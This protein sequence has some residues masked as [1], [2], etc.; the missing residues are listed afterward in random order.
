MNTSKSSLENI[1]LTKQEQTLFKRFKNGQHIALQRDEAKCI[2]R[3]GLIEE[4]LEWDGSVQLPWDGTF[5]ISDKG[6][7]YLQ[8]QQE[9]RKRKQIEWIRY[10]IT[11]AIA[12]AAFIK[13]F[14]F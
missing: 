4:H 13:S 5:K 12:V 2:W 11:T 6:K 3:F 9:K 7:H 10:I 1:V 8:F 14:F